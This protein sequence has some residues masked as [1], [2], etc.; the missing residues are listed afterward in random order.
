MIGGYG[1]CRALLCGAV[2]LAG[3][4]GGTSG[5]V[6][7][8]ACGASG[9]QGLIGKSLASVTLPAFSDARYIGPDSAV[10]KDYRLDRINFYLDDQGVITRI[11]C[12]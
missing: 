8:D 4:A 3:C 12:G 1:F 2:L 5:G 10:T 7:E 6:R 11:A 9:Y